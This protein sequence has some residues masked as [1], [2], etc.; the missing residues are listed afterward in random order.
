MYKLTVCVSYH[1]LTECNE[2]TLLLYFLT[3]KQ[4]KENKE[5]KEITHPDLQLTK[6]QLGRPD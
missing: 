2:L 4:N 5:N 3:E 1:L 6:S